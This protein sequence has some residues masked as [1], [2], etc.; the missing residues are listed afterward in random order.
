MRAVWV[1]YSSA[2]PVHTAFSYQYYPSCIKALRGGEHV[3]QTAAGGREEIAHQGPA[4]VEQNRRS[5]S[6][7]TMHGYYPALGIDGEYHDLDA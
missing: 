5:A 4:G 3:I 6:N 1:S 7:G 2:Q